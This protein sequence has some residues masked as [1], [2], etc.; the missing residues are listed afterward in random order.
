MVIGTLWFFPDILNTYCSQDSL[1]ASPYTIDNQVESISF[2]QYKKLHFVLSSIRDWKFEITLNFDRSFLTL[3]S[4]TS[5]WPWFMATHISVTNIKQ[6][7]PSIKEKKQEAN[8][9]NSLNWKSS[10]CNSQHLTP[11]LVDK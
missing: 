1:Q 8:N 3:H 4:S 7:R 9:G 2:L 11:V 5:K 10:V 6:N